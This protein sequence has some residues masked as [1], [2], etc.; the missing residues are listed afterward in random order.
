MSTDHPFQPSDEDKSRGQLIQELS[1]LRAELANRQQELTRLK[2]KD[3]PESE[4]RYRSLFSTMTE[5]FALH[6]IE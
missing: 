2:S 5:G 3:L 1:E 4:A 6:E